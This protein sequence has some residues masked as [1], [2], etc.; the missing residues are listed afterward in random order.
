MLFL[1]LNVVHKLV[2]VQELDQL[3]V[4]DR[5]NGR[6]IAYRL[7]DL[8]LLWSMMLPEL[9]GKVYSIDVNSSGNTF[10]PYIASVIIIFTTL[11][12]GG[13]HVFAVSTHSGT[14]V[15]YDQS[16]V[17]L[18]KWGPLNAVSFTTTTLCHFM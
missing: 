6:I 3:L 5:E 8:Q 16:G 11:L 18:N 2:I 1:A 4:A 13:I 15:T 9:G 12:A 14:G 17:V 10:C 7:Q